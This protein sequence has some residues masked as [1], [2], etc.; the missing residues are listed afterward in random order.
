M[1]GGRKTRRVT[2]RFALTKGEGQAPDPTL[3]TG[4]EKRDPRKIFHL[5]LG[6]DSEGKLP[7]GTRIVRATVLYDGV[8]PG[9]HGRVQGAYDRDGVPRGHPCPIIQFETNEPVDRE[10]LRRAVWESHFLVR[11]SGQPNGF[12]AEDWNGYTEAL[13]GEDLAKWKDWLRREGVWSGKAFAP[14]RLE[15]GVR[16]DLLGGKHPHP[17]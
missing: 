9:R 15:R 8:T 6:N 7:A 1:A 17:R 2:V 14:G 5:F 3:M 12:S 16:A 11:P 4:A 10:T 13:H